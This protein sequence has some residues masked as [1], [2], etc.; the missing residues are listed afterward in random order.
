MK[1]PFFALLCSI[2]CCHNTQSQKVK[3]GNALPHFE[4]SD[5]NGNRIR[6]ADLQNQKTLIAF[7]RYVGCPVCNFRVHQLLNHADQ[8]NNKGIRV[9]AIYES[10]NET[11]RN[12][13]ADTPMPFTIIGD[14]DLM[15]YKTFGLEKS[16]I[17]MMGSL[18][19]KQ[20]I[21]AM[22]AGRQLYNR[23]YKRDGNLNRLP[24]DFLIDDRGIIIKSYYGTDIG[25]HLP[26]A[27]IL[28]L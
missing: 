28:K 20:S 1:T 26:I 8:L 27:D 14:P 15:L 21:N 25:D 13:I 24:A 2:F 3:A 18:F 23:T 12:F 4:T 16:W 22:R 11:L 19:K 10:S 5:I 6:S 7:F 17:K 9:I